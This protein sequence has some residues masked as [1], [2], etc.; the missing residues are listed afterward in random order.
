MVD[1]NDGARE[2][3]GSVVMGRTLKIAGEAMVAPGSSLLLDGQILPGAAHLVGGLIARWAFGP[4]GWLLVA[5]NSYSRSVTGQGLT[6]YFR[7]ARQQVA[8]RTERAPRERA[9][10]SA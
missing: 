4:L 3:D 8:E 5:A 6:D 10:K 7:S 2:P 1:Q 9:A